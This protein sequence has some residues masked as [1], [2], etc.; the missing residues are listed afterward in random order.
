VHLGSAI[1]N[2]TPPVNK[3]ARVAETVALMDHL[4]DNRFEFGTGRG[5]STTEVFG[6]DIDDLSL[7]KE[8]WRETIT[9]IPKMWKHGTYSYE[10]RFFRMPEREVF[11]K[12]HGPMHPAMWV[13]AGSPP[14]FTEAGELGLGAFC[15][16]EGSAREIEP[17]VRNYKNAVANAT[18]V[19]DYVNNNIMAVTNLLCM[20]DRNKAFETAANMNM[21]HYT[22]LMHHWLDNIPTPDWF[23][24]W[25]ELLPEPKPEQIEKATAQGYSVVGDPDDCAKAIQ[26]WADIGVDQLTFSPTTN[27][28]PTDVVVESMELFGKEVLP[29]FDKDPVHSTTRYRQEAAAASR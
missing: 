4:L 6:F 26:L 13:A 23:P 21:N 2:I 28:L 1:F 3:P 11:P 8:M 25:P 19:G 12:P 22:S 27:T 9:E 18:P 7:T 29:R 16:S 24:K 17:L 10:G 14:T 5:S 20:E 15:F